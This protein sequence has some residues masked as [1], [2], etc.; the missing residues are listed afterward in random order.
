MAILI[1]LFWFSFLTFFSFIFLKKNRNPKSKL[2]PPPGPPSFPIIGNLHLLQGLPYRCFHQL[3]LKYGP[4]MLLR[5]GFVPTVVVSS[6][7]AAEEVL[8]TNDLETC[9]RPTFAGPDKLLNGSID[10]TFAQ[11]NESWKENRKVAMME[12]LNIKKVQS[13]R[14]IREEEMDFLVKKVSESALQ[15]SPVDLTKTFF[16]ITASIMCRSA[17]GQ[18]LHERED[19]IEELVIETALTLDCFRFSDSFP[20]RLG[21]FLDWLFQMNK[22]LNKVCKK[23]DA[24]CQLVIDEHLKPDGKKTRDPPAHIVAGLFNMIEKHGHRD[25]SKRNM[26][27]IKAVLVVKPYIII[28]DLF[29]GGIDNGAI[30]LIWVMAELMR[31]PRVM[32]KAQDEIRTILGSKRER[33]TEEDIDKVEYVKLII[34][35]SFRLH[36]PLP[37]LVRKTRSHVK[38]Q[39]YD[40]PPDTSIMINIWKIARDPK[41]WESPEDFIPER[42]IDSSIYYKGQNFELLPFGS[43]RRICPGIAMAI[44]ILELGLL[45]LLYFFDWRLPDGMIDQ[46]VD[47]EENGTISV[48]KKRPLLLVPRIWTII[49]GYDVPAK[50]QIFIN[51]YAI[52]RDPKYWEKPDE[53]NPDR[54]LDCSIDYKGLKFE[55]IPFGSGRRI[56]PG[57]ATAISIMEL[58]LLNLLYFFDWG[59]PEKD[60]GEEILTG[61]EDAL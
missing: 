50:T 10:I 25:S 11:Y 28:Y 35:E 29:L 20:C 27:Q 6:R 40:I 7:E 5:L 19:K 44:P 30:T 24:F 15:Q 49:Q 59:L 34:K 3:S 47:M 33:I 16:F 17:L 53:F 13:F 43:G 4:V 26:D 57:M 31:N 2:Q 21:W 38:I 23:L 52:A 8:K 12:L 9:S 46:G 55:L 58:G 39:G 51:A 42:F 61:N 18:N 32:R 54:F 45:N 36:P 14:Y 60:E 56:C 1:Y 37:L 41:H 48:G 22:R